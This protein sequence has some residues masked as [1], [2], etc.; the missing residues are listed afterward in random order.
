MSPEESYHLLPMG[1]QETVSSVEIDEDAVFRW[2]KPAKLYGRNQEESTLLRIFETKGNYRQFILISGADGVGKTRLAESLRGPLERKGG[3]FLR[4]TFDQHVSR[5]YAGLVTALSELVRVVWHSNDRDL[6]RRVVL[7]AIGAEIQV[8]IEM[9]PDL[10]LLFDLKD[11]REHSK[12]EESQQRFL[13]VC[14]KF[15]NAFASLQKPLVFLMDDLDYADDGSIDVLSYLL[16]DMKNPGYLVLGTCQE[17]PSPGTALHRKLGEMEKYNGVNM[18]RIRLECLN[19]MDTTSLV[20]DTYHRDRSEVESLARMAFGRTQGNPLF[21]LEFLRWLRAK[22]LVHIADDRWTWDLEEIEMHL[23]WQKTGDYFKHEIESVSE[24]TLDVLKVAACM[25]CHMTP[26]ILDCILGHTTRP[27]LHELVNR[28]VFIRGKC[29]KD[30]AFE[31]SVIHRRAYELIPEGD[32]ELFHLEVGRRLWRS[33]KVE[34]FDRF[35]FLILGQLERGKNLIHRPKERVSVAT[36]CLT[37]SR[38]AAQSSAFKAAASFLTFGLSLLDDSHWR[39]HYDLSLALFNTCA[40]V[41]LCI[42][43][44]E[45]LEVIAGVV[46]QRARNFQD[47]LDSSVALICL[48]NSSE[49]QQAS[50]DLAIDLLKRLGEEFPRRLCRAHLLSDLRGVQKMLRGKNDEQLLRLPRISDPKILDILKVLHLMNVSTMI[51]RPKLAPFVLLRSMKI[52]L[53]HGLSVFA[54]GA[55][56]MYAF[57]SMRL[58]DNVQEGTRFGKLAMVCLEEFGVLEYYPRVYFAYYTSIHCWNEPL[59]TALG[60]MLKAYRIAMLTGD[61]ESASLAGALYSTTAIETGFP[62]PTVLHEWNKFQD[63]MLLNKQN[64]Y[65]RITHA[66]VQA[67]H[68]LVGK[69]TDPLSTN[70]DLI[71]YNDEMRYALQNGSLVYETV[72]LCSR[73]LVLCM[74]NAT[75]LLEVEI[76]LLFKK[77]MKT[78]YGQKRVNFA[79]FCCLT[80]IAEARSNPRGQRKA[81]KRVRTVIEKNLTLWARASPQNFL[82]HLFLVEAELYSLQGKND[83]AFKQYVCAISTASEMRSL[84]MLAMTQERVARHLVRLDQEN[85]AKPYFDRA[86]ET[87]E[88]WGASAKVQV[89]KE[90][91]KAFT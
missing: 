80:T 86:I 30:Y 56:A 60:P 20:A 58:T 8:L 85:K 54:A 13:V 14:W 15:L 17:E 1:R 21:I 31:H 39:T 91:A 79:T 3:Y 46:Q 19:L 77:A 71:D 34:D 78:T 10:Q 6:V 26:S 73:M 28:G 61:N 33:T 67:I 65:L 43:D 90:E 83:E 69:S 24:S 16:S 32:R 81:I 35:L 74:F 70:G 22:D 82:P 41:C 9:I 66:Y 12:M 27:H 53:T 63:M 11:K 7:D 68:H 45:R 87:Y 72:L 38:K 64:S 42:A 50:I 29:E 49:R 25:G 18:T 36:L 2:S 48:Y 4:G 40:E 51:V 89:L 75:H 76:K 37:A 23:D 55:F 5:P 59:S 47:K 62:L 88:K 84:M 57:L 52:T 44:Y